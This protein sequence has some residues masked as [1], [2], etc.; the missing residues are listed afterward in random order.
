MAHRGLSEMSAYLSAFGANRTS[1]HCRR[2]IHLTR[3]THNGPRPRWPLSPRRFDILQSGAG[4]RGLNAIRSIQ[5]ARS[6]RCSAA[7]LPRGRS[8]R[9]HSSRAVLA[10]RDANGYGHEPRDGNRD[11]DPKYRVFQHPCKIP[12]FGHTR[13]ICFNVAPTCDASSG[14]TGPSRPSTLAVRWCAVPV[15]RMVRPNFY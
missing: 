13:A 9:A 15:L 1:G 6:S 14:Q 4:W 10:S 2:S 11:C 7:R 8:R 5:T 3:M 12:L